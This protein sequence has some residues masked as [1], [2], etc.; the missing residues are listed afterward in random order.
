MLGCT[1][2][3]SGRSGAETLGDKVR[4]HVGSELD[5]RGKPAPRKRPPPR[6]APPPRH[7]WTPAP[8][9]PAAPR[10][11]DPDDRFP[12]RILGRE[13]KLDPRAGIGYRGWY[14]QDYPRVDVD[15][16]GYPLW[17]VG[18]R[19]RIF[20]VLSI[21]RAAF[22]SSGTAGPRRSE[23]SVA[24][25]ASQALP[26]AAWLLGMI[27]VPIDFVLQPIVRYEARS[28]ETTAR[29]NAPVKIVP[30]GTSPNVDFDTLPATQAPLRMLSSYET[31]VVGVQY[32]HDNDVTGVL[33]APKGSVPPMYFGIGY[34]RY[35]KPYVLNVANVTLDD[36]LFDGRFQG[37]G[38]AYGVSTAQRVNKP[39]IDLSMQLGLGQVELLD[40]YTLNDALPSDWAIGY[41]Q[42]DVTV[43]YQLALARTA[44]TPILG[45]SV[46]AGGATF[47]AFKTKVR[48]GEQVDAPPLNWDILWSAQTYLTLPL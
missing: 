6:R 13:L 26:Q 28:F 16:A 44:P 31:I 40:D 38:L 45:A 19:A 4:G 21:E 48:E 22:E 11:P 14:A 41:L 24:V 1:L 20:R 42:G 5:Q 25:K 2:W 29:P 12:V 32:N 8:A 18:L 30:H 27:G 36:V 34:V 9:A 43:G 17:T 23:A 15:L 33:E 46:S 3:V 35:N 47:F 39:F 10:A 7:D 37:L